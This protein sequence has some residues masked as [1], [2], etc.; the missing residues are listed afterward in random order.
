MRPH[1]LATLLALLLAAPAAAQPEG[2]TVS[3]LLV[4]PSPTVSEVVVSPCRYVGGVETV[5]LPGR[6]VVVA[7]SADGCWLFSDISQREGSGT[8]EGD[9]AVLHYEDGRFKLVGLTPLK[10]SYGDIVL[11]HDGKTLVAGGLNRVTFLDVAKLE[12]G[13]ADPVTAILPLGAGAVGLA[14][15]RDDRLLFVTQKTAARLVVVDFAQARAGRKAEP[16]YID[17]GLIPVGLTFSPDGTRLFSI[18]EIANPRSAQPDCRA[19]DGGPAQYPE[20]VLTVIDVR[21]LGADPSKAVLAVRQAGCNPINVALS[22]DGGMLWVTAR[23][24]GRLLGFAADKLVGAPVTAPPEMS[25]KVGPAPIG[26]AV[27]ADGQVWVADSNR[28]SHGRPG[29]LTALSPSGQVLRTLPGGVF[30]RN[31][32]FLPDGKTLV[33]AQSDSHALQ[34]VPTDAP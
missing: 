17:T 19:E 34:F 13:D 28:F 27:R 23:G 3:E 30:P 22:P 33:V 32:G 24:D 15:S 9:L 11:S 16:L 8:G 5:A 12:A 2:H 26:V 14:I 29:S 7:A 4:M 25:I 1:R 6:P 31:V 10:G 20:G 21:A 18:S